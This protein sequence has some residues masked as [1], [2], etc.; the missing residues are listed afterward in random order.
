MKTLSFIAFFLLPI[1]SISQNKNGCPPKSVKNH[2]CGNIQEDFKLDT[3]SE[4][5]LMETFFEVRLKNKLKKEEDNIIAGRCIDLLNNVI[6]DSDF[7]NLIYQYKKYEFAKWSQ[8]LNDQ[9][10]EIDNKQ[11]LN[12]LVNGNPD[13]NERPD[14]VIIEIELNLYGSPIKMPKETVIGKHAN[15]NKIFNKRWFFRNRSTK[16]I[17]SNWMHEI[18]H[19]KGLRHC[20]YCN[21][22]RDYSVPYVINRIFSEVSKKY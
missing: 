9:W 19:S 8:N 12:T 20:F 5:Y 18:T 16:R 11:I 13:N 10:L 6:N 7:W 3:T 1:V 17:A 4:I 15:G 2:K 14:T 22:Q 21:Q